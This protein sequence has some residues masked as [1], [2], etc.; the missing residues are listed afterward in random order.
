[1]LY[2]TEPVPLTMG[3]STAAYKPAPVTNVIAGSTTVKSAIS[4]FPGASWTIVFKMSP[5]FRSAHFSTN[6]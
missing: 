2:S 5:Q 6:R 3:P 1:M 4:L